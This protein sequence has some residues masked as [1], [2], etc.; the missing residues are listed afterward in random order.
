MSDFNLDLSKEAQVSRSPGGNRRCP[1]TGE[2]KRNCK[3]RPCIGRRSKYKGQRKQRDARKG[4]EKVF[5]SAGKYSSQTGHEELWRT[6]VRVEVKSGAMAKTVDTFYRNTKGQS[7]QAKAI[8]DTRPY[9]AVA[10]PDGV[11]FG[12]AVVRLDHL[13]AFMSAARGE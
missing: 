8:G 12:Y 7:D 6:R 3:C 13:D 10:M 1:T 9:V 5:G 2:L 11:S 4:I